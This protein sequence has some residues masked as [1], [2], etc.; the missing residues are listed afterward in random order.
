VKRGEWTVPVVFHPYTPLRIGRSRTHIT[1]VSIAD[2]GSEDMVMPLL[3]PDILDRG[4]II[5]HEHV[6]QMKPEVYAAARQAPLSV[7]LG[8]PNYGSTRQ[9]DWL[10]TREFA[11]VVRSNTDSGLSMFR[12]PSVDIA[13]IASVRF[14]DGAAEVKIRL[15]PKYLRWALP[16]VRLMVEVNRQMGRHVAARDQVLAARF[17][18][19]TPIIDDISGRPRLIRNPVSVARLSL[20]IMKEVASRSR[21]ENLP[22]WWRKWAPTGSFTQGGSSI[23]FLELLGGLRPE[24]P[25]SL[26]GRIY[27]QSQRRNALARGT[28]VLIE[29]TA[30]A[31]EAGFDAFISGGMLGKDMEWAAYAGVDGVGLGIVVDEDAVLNRPIT[32]GLSAERIR[33]ALDIRDA[34]EASL[35]GRGAR[36]LYQ[37][38][39]AKFHRRLA[40]GSRPL[41]NKLLEAMKA[42]DEA[43]VADLL[44][45]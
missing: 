24:K 25:R 16:M 41:Y 9:W 15:S 27:S 30:V 19:N 28:K 33:E 40:E 35:L 7:Y 6:V 22:N 39:F 18:L 31:H 44:M 1:R 45:A 43:R 2:P 10:R 8:H 20:E 21:R 36:K 3:K 12:T 14:R 38:S 26:K 32:Q 11:S 13:S 37:L 29:L 42:M 17:D 5:N 34:A 23:S 4:I